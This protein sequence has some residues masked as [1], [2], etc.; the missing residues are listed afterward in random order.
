MEETGPLV[1][2]MPVVMCSCLV[3]GRNNYSTLRVLN[4]VGYSMR[5]VYKLRHI[6]FTRE[7]NRGLTKTKARGQ[8]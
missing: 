3:P 8:S 6:R 5:F 2:V 4:T 7:A 1:P